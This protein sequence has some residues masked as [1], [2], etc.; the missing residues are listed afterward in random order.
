VTF[1][2][3]AQRP[4]LRGLS[5]RVAAGTSLAVVGGTGAGKSTLASLVPRL[6]DP[7]SGRVLLDGK[8]V[9][10]ATLGSLRMQVSLVLQDAFLF[11]L[12]VA[13]NI[14]Y[15]RPGASAEQIEAAARAAG[16][17]EFIARLP[18]GYQTVVGERGATLS[19][20]ERQ[21]LSIARAVL[22]DAPVLVLDEPTSA[23][24]ASTEASVMSALRGLMRGRTTLIIAHRLSTVRG[25]DRIVVLER[26]EIAEQGTHE[27]LMAR[28][29]AYATLYNAVH[30]RAERNEAAEVAP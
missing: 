11:P 23:L 3:E 22:R 21:R 10:E 30:G 18:Q 8:D 6:F 16:A 5:L 15:G 20:G 17:H 19:G 26:G 13:E 28:G 29:G 14:A 27:Q 12:S 7:W 24:D 2:Y 1:G 25:A 4:V 9:R